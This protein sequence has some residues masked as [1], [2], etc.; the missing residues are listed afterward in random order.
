MKKST[1]TQELV[2]DLDEA[3]LVASSW[4]PV[5]RKVVQAFSEG[6]FDLSRGIPSVAPI[7]S[8]TAN[9][10]RGYVAAYGETLAELPDE[11]WDSS[12]SQWMGTHWDVL[13]DLWTAES[14]ESDMV[15]GVRVFEVEHGFRF[16]V[17][18]VYVP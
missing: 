17:G 18:S 4:R 5:L 12:L 6:D 15:L 9:Q 13:V 16:E 10:I 2:K 3:H 8:T 14:G 1:E 7:A 11:A